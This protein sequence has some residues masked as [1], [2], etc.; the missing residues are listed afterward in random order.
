MIFIFGPKNGKTLVH[1]GQRSLYMN[2]VLGGNL[3]GWRIS[4]KDGKAA[5]FDIQCRLEAS[6]PTAGS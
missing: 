3:T 5:N 6:T 1:F 4:R 2:W